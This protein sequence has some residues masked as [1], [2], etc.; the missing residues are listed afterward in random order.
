MEMGLVRVVRH[1]KRPLN[2]TPH[3]QTHHKSSKRTVTARVKTYPR[4]AR[5]SQ[6]RSSR[7][8]E[9]KPSS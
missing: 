3:D 4:N 5:V 1:L 6:R 8:A 9:W 2:F 7:I